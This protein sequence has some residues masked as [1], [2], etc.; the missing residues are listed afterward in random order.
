MNDKV[1]LARRNALKQAVWQKIRYSSYA[2][3]TNKEPIDGKR[4]LLGSTL[5]ACP[6]LGFNGTETLRKPAYLWDRKAQKS[7][8]TIKITEGFP[9][10]YC[11][12]H[13]WGRWRGEAVQIEGVD[14]AVPTNS[15]LT[16]F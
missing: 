16:K 3:A 2:E 11:I 10:F 4:T 7:V 8:K 15:M 14:W 13:T 12:S 5:D 6:W 1:Y 9:S